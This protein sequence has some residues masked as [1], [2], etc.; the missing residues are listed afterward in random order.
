MALIDKDS[1]LA[2][3]N[4]AV[5]DV[6]A[7]VEQSG[8]DQSAQIAQLQQQLA[9]AQAQLADLQSKIDA[10]AASLAA[11]VQKEADI[12]AHADK[13]QSKIDSAIAALQA[14]EAVAPAPS[15]DSSAPQS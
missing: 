5:A 12:Q 8:G 14:S 6:S 13:L 11:E 9:D 7:L 1:V 2:I 15:S 4:K 10:A 3:M